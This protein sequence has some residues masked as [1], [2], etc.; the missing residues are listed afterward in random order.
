MSPLFRTHP[1][2]GGRPHVQGGSFEGVV[3]RS[4]IGGSE[5]R[6]TLARLAGPDFQ[7]GEQERA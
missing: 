1:A 7:G 4:V 5:D 3:V 2:W 6:G